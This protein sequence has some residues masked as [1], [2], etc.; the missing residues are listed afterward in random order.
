M[1]TLFLSLLFTL[2]IVACELS[3][4]KIIDYDSS[5]KEA[6]IA[7]ALQD[8]YSAFSCGYLVAQG[9]MSEEAFLSEGQ[10]LI[11]GILE[12]PV[13][14]KKVLTIGDKIAGF[15]QVGKCKEQSLEALLRIIL[16]SGIKCD[17]RQIASSDPQM[18][19]TDK[20]CAEFGQVG[21]LLIS[22]EFRK[23]GFGRMLLK[24]AYQEIVRRWP[25]LLPARLGVNAD[26]LAAIKL[27]ESEGYKKSEIQPPLS[28][29][30]KI[31]EYQKSI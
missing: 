24:D 22:K 4:P 18:K 16:K 28:E 12:D 5:Y 31:I 2:N 9:H 30:M 8:P 13:Q 7:I 21:M 3:V 1:K 25:L 26:N 11:T 14:V 27:Y 17:V 23:R 19:K 15:S 20:E 29:R 6:I 10:K